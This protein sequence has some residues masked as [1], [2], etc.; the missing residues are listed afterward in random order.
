MSEL[1]KAIAPE[2][3][4]EACEKYTFRRWPNMKHADREEV[5]G[6]M[7]LAMVE[8]ASKAKEGGP[9]RSY[10]WACAIGEAKHYFGM[11]SNV[12]KAECVKLDFHHGED[13]DCE[14]EGRTTTDAD[15]LADKSLPEGFSVEM[16]EALNN[17]SA[18]ERRVIVCR[19]IDG[20]SAEETAQALGLNVRT[21]C[22]TVRMTIHRLEE[23]A[24]ASLRAL[25]TV[26]A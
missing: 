24:L 11:R 17:L 8:A 4:I 2:S 5:V 14:G 9:V 3:I 16:G 21:D 7:A 12:C 25:L 13:G 19:F 23:K 18:E 6:I 20:K 10:Q 15:M 22:S 1:L 26:A